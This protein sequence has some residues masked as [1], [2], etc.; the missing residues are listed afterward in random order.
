M[1]PNVTSDAGKTQPGREL[2]FF[3]HLMLF[4]SLYLAYLT[5]QPFLHPFLF[6]A[7]LASLCPPL[8]AFFERSFR[9]RR[10]LAAFCV[11][12]TAACSSVSL[13]A[14]EAQYV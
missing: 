4:V 5:L 8:R 1:V 14:E 10:N 11:V 9:G 2:R 7:V 3:V 13:P 6:A 12:L